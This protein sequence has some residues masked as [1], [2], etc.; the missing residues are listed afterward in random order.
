MAEL[1]STSEDV[2]SRRPE[3]RQNV[4]ELRLLKNAALKSTEMILA[5]EEAEKIFGITYATSSE[6]V[7]RQLVLSKIEQEDDELFFSGD[8]LPVS[9]RL[10]RAAVVTDVL[11][12]SEVYRSGPLAES[13][14]IIVQDFVEESKYPF[15]SNYTFEKFTGGS[16]VAS[17]ARTD[18]FHES[19]LD[20]REMLPYDFNEF[21]QQ[22]RVI[23]AIRQSVSVK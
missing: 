23:Q 16:M 10:G 1:Q 3:Y 11:I 7:S 8:E 18:I 15:I 2:F 14:S 21:N 9:I 13:M 4:S 19:G 12:R 17:V 6:V 20:E 22:L 5:A